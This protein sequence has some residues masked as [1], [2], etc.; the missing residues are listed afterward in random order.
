M[1]IL[2]RVAFVDERKIRKGLIAAGMLLAAGATAGCSVNDLSTPITELTTAVEGSTTA[3]EQLDAKL[4]DALNESWQRQIIAGTAQL[5]GADNSCTFD[6]KSCS[7]TVREVGGKW[8]SYPVQSVMPKAHVGLNA[9]K[10]Y[11]GSLKALVDADTA[12]KVSASANQAIGSLKNIEN[13][14]ATAK[15]ET[16]AGIVA[17]YETPVSEAL[18][19]FVG[20][21]VESVKYR[22]LAK[23]TKEADPVITELAL[24]HEDLARPLTDTEA[25]DAAAAYRKKR[26]A[27]SEKRDA[28]E[29]KKSDIREFLAA[30]SDYD[31]VLKGSHARPLKAFAEAHAKLAL[32]L[33]GDGSVSLSD[34][35]SFIDKVREEAKTFRGIVENFTKINEETE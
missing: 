33:N 23:A 20:Q 32:H 14:V 15:G 12:G 16:P 5:R 29:I 18:T 26:N 28:K 11:V 8:Q 9:L 2:N 22:A 35:L 1:L 19:W 25:T 24:Y 17:K 7:L 13:Q 27:F 30:A 31:T 10:G 34:A 3:I 21:Y 6:A 4:T